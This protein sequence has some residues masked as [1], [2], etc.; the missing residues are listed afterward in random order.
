MTQRPPRH[1]DTSPAQAALIKQRLPH[2]KTYKAIHVINDQ[3][4]DTAT[5]YLGPYGFDV[6]SDAKGSDGYKDH[7]GIQ[8][9][10][11]NAKR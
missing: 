11:D 4:P 10:I 3:S 7:A 1:G 9:F 6:N 2:M 5:R 8:R